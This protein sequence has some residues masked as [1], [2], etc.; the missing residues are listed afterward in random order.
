MEVPENFEEYINRLSFESLA[1]VALNKNLGLLRQTNLDPE[2]L[3]YFSNVR[4]FLQLVYHLDVEP[5]MW[6]IIP[7]P[8]YYESMRVQTELFDTTQKYVN[9]TLKELEEKEKSGVQTENLGILEKML[10]INR[11]MAIVMAMDMLL[12]GVDTVSVTV[13]NMSFK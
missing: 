3:K 2:I 11:K 13:G 12:A 5:S 10:K 4:R 8:R 9:E 7:T 1:L 6:K